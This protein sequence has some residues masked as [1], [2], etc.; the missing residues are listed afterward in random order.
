MIRLY[1]L[2]IVY[3]LGYIIEIMDQIGRPVEEYLL[4]RLQA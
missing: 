1:G 2:I 3:G 4:L